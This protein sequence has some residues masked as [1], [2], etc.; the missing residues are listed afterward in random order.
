M[1]TIEKLQKRAT[2][3]I[4]SLKQCTYQERLSALNL[5]SLQYRRLRMDLIVTYKILQ[6]TVHLRKDHF[7]L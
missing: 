5:P 2:K 6:G 7:L 1:H 4:P 3:L